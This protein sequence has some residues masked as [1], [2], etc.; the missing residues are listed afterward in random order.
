MPQ[1]SRAKKGLILNVDDFGAMNFIDRA[2][3]TAASQGAINS[4]SAFVTYGDKGLKRIEK[5]HQDFGNKVRI[6]L[7]FSITAGSPISSYSEI[8]HLI[9]PKSL[10]RSKKNGKFKVLKNVQLFDGLEEQVEHELR[11]QLNTLAQC[12]GGAHNIDH[13]NSHQSLLA[14]IPS[15]WNRL[16]KVLSS[17]PYK[18]IAV[19]SPL[20]YKHFHD[21]IVRRGKLLPI[22]K[23]A[24]SHLIMHAD[25]RGAL[26]NGKKI[27]GLKNRRRQ[28]VNRGIPVSNMIN[29]SY[30]GQPGHDILDKFIKD[31]RRGQVGEMVFHLGQ[32]SF[33]NE[34][35]KY[36]PHGILKK[37]LRHRASELEHL[38]SYKIPEV[39]SANPD[40]ELVNYRNHLGINY[41]PKSPELPDLAFLDT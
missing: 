36:K 14:F 11:N 5:L 40:L 32:G 22:E 6:G 34:F 13:V 21:P 8:K 28:A 20:R 7:H 4:V 18:G 1:K 19:R 23:L 37:S 31:L 24:A 38:L 9:D 33:E 26:I 2:V 35:K 25:T 15:F 27:K 16:M 41:N 29:T 30:F 10:D 39:V 17:H 3:R 12:I